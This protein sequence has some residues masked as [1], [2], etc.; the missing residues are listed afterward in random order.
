M[1]VVDRVTMAKLDIL[2][3]QPWWRYLA[4][5]LKWVEDY[6]QATAWTD[7]VTIGYNPGYVAGLQPN[8]LIGLFVHELFHVAL[9]H[10]LRIEDRERKRFNIAADRVINGHITRARQALPNGSL[11]PWPEPRAAVEEVYPYITPEEMSQ[12]ETSGNGCGEVRPWPLLGQSKQQQEKQVSQVKS[13]VLQ[14][15]HQAKAHGLLPAGFDALIA[16]LERPEVDWRSVLA[17]YISQLAPIDYSYQRL[18]RRYLPQ[19]AIP[20]LRVPSVEAL[21]VGDSSGSMGERNELKRAAS[22]ARGVAEACGQQTTMLWVDSQVQNVE[23]LTPGEISLPRPKGRGGTNFRPAFEW[24]KEN[25][26]TP[27][28]LIYLTDG[29]V[30]NDWPEDPGYPVIWVIIGN[31][32]IVAPWGKTIN[33]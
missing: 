29:E 4:T 11:P 28:V 16:E 17:A 31:S 15:F 32:H 8:E 7:G 10:H 14:G 2:R 23:E 20:M 27:G 18:N 26:K 30:G 13:L 5:S 33:I 19:M 6:A 25:G 24:V 21:L 22:E 9:L 3:N 1:A 12:F